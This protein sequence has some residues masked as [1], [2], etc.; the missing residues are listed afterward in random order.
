[1][2]KIKKAFL[3]I[4]LL[5]C[6]TFAG[7]DS[8]KF[9]FTDYPPANYVDEQGNY[10]GF[11]YD[12]TCEAFEKRLNIPLEISVLPWPRCQ[13]LVKSGIYDMMLT[14]PTD[15]RLNYSIATDIPVWRKVRVIYT[16]KDHPD[17]QIINGLNGLDDIK[18]SGYTIVSYRGNQGIRDEVE[19]L[20]I[21]VIY[22]SSVEGM[23]QM[24]A[25]GRADLIIEEESIAESNLQKLNLEEKI[26]KT[27]GIAS[28]SYFHLLISKRSP[29]AVM[30]YDLNRVL[31]EM[32]QD[33]TIDGILKRYGL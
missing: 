12:I 5:I 1:M 13:E 29:H 20:D 27:N 8:I 9:V 24:L 15:E 10:T 2:I 14:I 33:G 26:I 7:A 31:E 25:A 22:A 16:Y 6:S 17:V 11:L 28:E 32:Q 23:Y 4:P 19:A 21:P 18:G 3:L 30:I